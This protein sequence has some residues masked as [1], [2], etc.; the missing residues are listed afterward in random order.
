[1][2]N[3]YDA[4]GEF[5]DYWTDSRPKSKS[6]SK[7]PPKR[8]VKYVGPGHTRVSYAHRTLDIRFR[9]TPQQFKAKQRSRRRAGAKRGAKNRSPRGYG[10]VYVKQ[11]RYGNMIYVDSKGRNVTE[12]YMRIADEY[13]SYMMDE[14][15]KKD[16]YNVEEMRA[17]LKDSHWEEVCGHT[18]W[19]WDKKATVK[20]FKK[21]Q[22]YYGTMY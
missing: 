1:M 19:K 6:K 13:N 12:K 2:S 9:Q 15:F 3:Y 11:D 20:E 7:T 5:E 17:L 16:A 10:D 14:D 21:Y 4:F 18:R 22:S 8:S